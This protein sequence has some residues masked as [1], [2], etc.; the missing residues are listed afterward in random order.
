MHGVAYDYAKH[1]E[2]A[3]A[4]ARFSMLVDIPSGG[5]MTISGQPDLVLVD[6]FHLIDFK[7]T[8]HVPRLWLTFICP[9]TGKVIRE[10]Q[11]SPRGKTISCPYCEMG[12]HPKNDVMEE[13]P[14]RAYSR[15]VQQVSLYRLLLTENGIEVS[16]VDIVYQDMVEQ[17]RI[18][19][20]LMPILEAR[21]LVET[22]VALHAQ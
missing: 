2:Y 20:R 3:I 16:S 8:K 17:L 18:P 6:R 13:G 1:D 5:I 15:H 21:D 4:E 10:G 22:L 11:C 14:P 19:I 9:E 7:T 12:E